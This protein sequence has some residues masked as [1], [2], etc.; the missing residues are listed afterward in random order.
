MKIRLDFV[1][2]SSSSSFILGKPKENRL[3]K[4]DGLKYLDKLSEKLGEHIYKEYIIDLK[5]DDLIEYTKKDIEFVLEAIYWYLDDSECSIEGEYDAEAGIWW[6]INEDYEYEESEDGF[7]FDDIDTIGGFTQEKIKK[8]LDFA[9]NNLGEIL[10]GSEM[11]DC[12]GAFKYVIDDE[13]I[14][15]KCNHMG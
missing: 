2:N 8:I 4:R 1:T 14:R 9:H 10:I 6:R 12:S 13:G 3:S 11:E 5:Y 15:F 7:W